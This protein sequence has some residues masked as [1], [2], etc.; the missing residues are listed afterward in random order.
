MSAHYTGGGQ[1]KFGT[2][3]SI[4]LYGVIKFAWNTLWI[5]QCFGISTQYTASDNCFRILKG[6]YHFGPSFAVGYRVLRFVPSIHTCSPS[7]YGLKCLLLCFFIFKLPCTFKILLKASA[8][9]S[10]SF[11]NLSSTA[12]TCEGCMFHL[13]CGVN[14]IISSYGVFFVVLLGHW[15]CTNSANGN[16]RSQSSC[17]SSQ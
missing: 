7:L 9:I 16:H 4:S 14:P 5:F 1:V 10:L 12:G 3:I 2:C 17:F 6:L 11:A 13:S 8:H 15:L